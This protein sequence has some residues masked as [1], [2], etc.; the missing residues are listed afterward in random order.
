LAAATAALAADRGTN[1]SVEPDLMDRT[2]LV[3]PSRI[4]GSAN[5]WDALH[6]DASQAERSDSDD[7]AAMHHGK[8]RVG[9]YSGGADHYRV[10]MIARHHH[11]PHLLLFHVPALLVPQAT[12]LRRR[13]RQVQ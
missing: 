8:N 10:S 12:Q 2:I 13:V 9:A 3:P 5:L 7:Q 6:S 11:A 1:S 4:L